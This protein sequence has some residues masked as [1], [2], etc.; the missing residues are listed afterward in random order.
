VF[1]FLFIYCF[2][3]ASFVLVYLSLLIIIANMFDVTTSIIYVN[4]WLQ[5]QNLCMHA[6]GLSNLAST[7]MKT[8]ICTSVN[9]CT[10][11]Y[12][13]VGSSASSNINNTNININGYYVLHSHSYSHI[14]EDTHTHTRNTTMPML[15]LIFTLIPPK[16]NTHTFSYLLS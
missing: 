8:D 15:T 12:T 2:P 5:L 16:L 10:D 14:Y 9:M 3:P 7:K 1:D 13:S 11:H 6:L 4:Y